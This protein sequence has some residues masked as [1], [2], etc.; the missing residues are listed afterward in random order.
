MVV[1]AAALTWDHETNRRETE[2]QRETEK[3]DAS[4]N[5]CSEGA[6]M[7]DRPNQAGRK[8]IRWGALKSEIAGTER[9]GKGDAQPHS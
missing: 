1:V 2:R 4:A 6:D 3:E 5:V 9:G 8:D 7:S